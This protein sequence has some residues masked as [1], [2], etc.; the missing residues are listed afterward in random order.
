MRK[1][2]QLRNG[3]GI[4]ST[5]LDHIWQVEISTA[6]TLSVIHD[7]VCAMCTWQSPI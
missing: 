5:V 7:A 2:V 4:H 3:V 6:V 1:S